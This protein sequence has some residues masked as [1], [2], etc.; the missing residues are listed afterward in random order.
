MPRTVKT[1]PT[2]KQKFEN[3]RG[4]RDQT[5]CSRSCGLVK[6]KIVKTFICEL[7]DKSFDFVGRTKAKFCPGCR[8][9]AGSMRA[10]AAAVRQGRIKQ[11][12][13]G[14][15]GNQVGNQSGRR[16]GKPH[17]PG[18]T[19]VDYRALALDHHGAVCGLCDNGRR[20]LVV[21]HRNGDETDHRISNLIPLCYSCHKYAHW[22]KVP[23]AEL[24][25]RLQELLKRKAEVKS[26]RKT[27]TPSTFGQSEVKV[28]GNTAP[29]RND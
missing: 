15:G 20:K 14:R 28:A 1:C 6:A 22:Q 7:C 13:V 11:P 19:A 12:G 27:G 18:R 5:Y 26:R 29:S 23:N 4:R 2:C 21:H 17:L 9:A 24:E 10:V 16:K 8:R 25:Q 3:K